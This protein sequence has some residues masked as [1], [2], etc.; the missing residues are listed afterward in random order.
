MARV[1][2][3]GAYLWRIYKEPPTL[4]LHP[5]S[6]EHTPSA[7]IPKAEPWRHR[8]DGHVRRKRAADHSKRPLPLRLY[9]SSEEMA[10]LIV[11]LRRRT[12][13]ILRGSSI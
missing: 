13:V 12:R 9:E 8:G 1:E 6:A 4:L 5:P 7:L 2:R 3:D 10:A 11:K